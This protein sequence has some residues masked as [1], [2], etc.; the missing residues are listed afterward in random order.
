MN[1]KVIEPEIFTDKRM[2]PG[3]NNYEK[4]QRLPES[5]EEFIWMFY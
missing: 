3:I 5:S 1:N 2:L 4:N